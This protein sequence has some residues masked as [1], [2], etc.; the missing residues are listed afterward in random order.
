LD[1]KISQAGEIGFLTQFLDVSAQFSLLFADHRISD[2][3][4]ARKPRQIKGVSLST[5]F[6]RETKLA[7]HIGSAAELVEFDHGKAAQTLW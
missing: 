2:L 5:Y 1:N 4:T 6:R 3:S 7:T